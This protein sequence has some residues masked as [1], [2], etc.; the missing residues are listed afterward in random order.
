MFLNNRVA[1][2]SQIGRLSLLA[3]LVILMLLLASVVASNAGQFVD[4][5]SQ[6][7]PSQPTQLTDDISVDPTLG[8]LC[9]RA[10]SLVR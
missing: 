2:L 6:R 10:C 8:V 5:A 9:Y 1:N 4:T 3:L 7:D